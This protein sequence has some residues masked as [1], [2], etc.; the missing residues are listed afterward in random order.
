MA[1]QV[2]FLLFFQRTGAQFPVRP[3]VLQFQLQE[4][5][6]LWSSGVPVLTCTYPQTERHARK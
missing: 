5:S 4:I 2:N 6:C 3:G 1:Q